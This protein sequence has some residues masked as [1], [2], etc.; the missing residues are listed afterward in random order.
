MLPEA[1]HDNLLYVSDAGTNGVYVFS[2]PKARYVGSLGGFLAEPHGV[3][4]DQA[5]NV[6]V[7]EFGQFY[8]SSVQEYAHGGTSPIATLDASG[9]PEG[10]S[11]DPTTGN[12]AV[13]IY[14]YGYP[15]GVAVYPEAQGTPT[16]YTDPNFFE[17]T[18]CSYDNAGNLF[19][20]GQ[21]SAKGFALAELP[22]GSNSLTDIR[23]RATIN[24]GVNARLQSD[25]KQL[26]IG[27]LD[28][29]DS[30]KYSIFRVRLSGNRAKIIDVLRV[31][32]AYGYFNVDTAFII[33]NNRITLTAAFQ[34]EGRALIYRFPGGAHVHAT[35]KFGSKYLDGV[36]VS[37][38]PHR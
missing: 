7:T 30:H 21:N 26:A 18:G 1:S 24:G 11:V 14:S 28:G 35:G 10:C 12:L 38:A 8:N 16:L 32:D 17:M 3:C 27:S 20:A 6:F 15:T 37:L 13:A 19:V 5:G 33:Q 29:S 2:Y 23:V 9:E 22:A 25:G 31:S 34:P 4:A 36:T